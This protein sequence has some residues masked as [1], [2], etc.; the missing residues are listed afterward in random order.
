MQSVEG[1]PGACGE[2]EPNAEAEV[3]ALDLEHLRREGPT[4]RPDFWTQ[5]LAPATIF[6]H[7][8]ADALVVVDEP[9]DI[10]SRLEERDERAV[11]ARAEL[12]R[13]GRIPRGSA[14]SPG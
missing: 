10:V 1:S 7:L 5:F 14:A 13:G 3:L 11:H 12:E 9:H 2:I 6:D 4:A 8:P